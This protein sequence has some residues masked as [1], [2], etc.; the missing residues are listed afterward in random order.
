MQTCITSVNARA[1]HMLREATLNPE[2][3]QSQYTLPNVSVEL[4]VRI[5]HDGILRLAQLPVLLFEIKFRDEQWWEE[6]AAGTA[7]S[8]ND[9]ILGHAASDLV[10][11]SR[12]ILTVAWLS[13]RADARTAALVTG[14]SWRAAALLAEMTPS[15]LTRVASVGAKFLQPRWSG[16]Q[17]FWETLLSAACNQD[18][19]MLRLAKLHSVQLSC[20]VGYLRR[21]ESN[22]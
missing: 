8:R 18:D 7:A 11:L 19:H 16:S 22:A 1:I 2:R 15:D 4:W 14:M 21:P 10:D 9:D 17:S 6:V 3:A 12:E 5:D 13:A 20:E